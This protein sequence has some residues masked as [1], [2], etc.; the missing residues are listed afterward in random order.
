MSVTFDSR[1]RMG[2]AAK[3]LRALL[4]AVLVAL[5]VASA[6]AGLSLQMRL[7][8]ERYAAEGRGAGEAVWRYFAFF[9]LLTNALAAVVVSAWMIRRPPGPRLLA[10]AATNVFMVGAVYHFALAKLSDP[11]GLQLLADRLVHT[12]T[13]VLFTVLWLV[14][15]PRRTLKWRDTLWM[16]IYPT[17]YFFYALGRGAIDGF[18]PYWFLD[19][20]TL[21]AQQMT[22]NGAVLMTLFGA[23]SLAFVAINREFRLRRTKGP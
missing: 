12:A 18:Y 11:Q 9:T 22:I 19:L 20:P 8:I 10:T 2:Q 1:P 23:V 5:T 21:G 13:P 17:V 15:A 6:W 14:A 3:I 4:I 16:M 7:L